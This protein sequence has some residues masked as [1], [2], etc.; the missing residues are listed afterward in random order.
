MTAT[1][2]ITTPSTIT[3][4]ITFAVGTVVRVQ[5]NE[6]FFKIHSHAAWSD[7]DHRIPR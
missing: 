3:R 4:P 2:P 1:F 7:D 5:H 6:K